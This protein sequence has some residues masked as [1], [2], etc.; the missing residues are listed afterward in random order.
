[1]F[2]NTNKKINVH[3][4]KPQFYC[5]KVGFKGVKTIYARFRD[6]EEVLTVFMCLIK[7]DILS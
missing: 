2:L 6:A 7:A 3:A 4:C 5:M 1:M